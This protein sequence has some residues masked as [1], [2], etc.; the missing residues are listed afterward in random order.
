LSELSRSWNVNLFVVFG[1]IRVKRLL[2]QVMSD[3][4]SKVCIA[5]FPIPEAVRVYTARDAKIGSA[6]VKQP[7][8]LCPVCIAKLFKFSC[9]DAGKAW[10]KFRASPWHIPIFESLS[11]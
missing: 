10:H 9:F 11:V 3:L 1:I 6:C 8:T 4:K 5:K 7:L 2:A